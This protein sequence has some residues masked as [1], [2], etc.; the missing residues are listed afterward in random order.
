M[1]KAEKG[2]YYPTIIAPIELNFLLFV[3]KIYNKTW[4]SVITHI[5][6]VLSKI[7]HNF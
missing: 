7:H 2:N 4:Y 5:S 1:K 6:H 3:N